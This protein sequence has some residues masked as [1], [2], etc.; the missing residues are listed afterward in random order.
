MVH[1]N[2]IHFFF[3]N[4]HS[5]QALSTFP[6][7]SICTIEQNVDTWLPQAHASLLPAGWKHRIVYNVTNPQSHIPKLTGKLSQ[8]SGGSTSTR[9]WLVRCPQS[10]GH[11]V[12]NRKCSIH[13]SYTLCTLHF[14]SVF[15]GLCLRNEIHGLEPKRA[16]LAVLSVREGWNTLSVSITVTLANHGGLRAHVCGSERMAL[17]SECVTSLPVCLSNKSK[18]CGRL[19]SCAS[20]EAW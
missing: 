19:A 1:T 20:E 3:F 17:S 13:H 5:V 14:A 10:F 4:H 18:R 12:F 2:L 6:V 11:I 16:K 7:F 15:H 8:M 9:V